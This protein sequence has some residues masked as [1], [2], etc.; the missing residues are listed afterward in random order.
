MSDF[1][2]IVVAELMTKYIKLIQELNELYTRYTKSL[3]LYF[4]SYF[5]EN[6]FQKIAL[7]VI[8]DN[9]M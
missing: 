7:T 9:N 3:F 2:K 8:P 5:I 1:F 6:E 4:V